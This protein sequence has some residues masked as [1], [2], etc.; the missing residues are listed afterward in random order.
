M[1]SLNYVDHDDV[2]F[3]FNVFVFFIFSKIK[4]KAIKRFRRGFNPITSY[5][6]T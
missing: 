2:S 5:E 3:D 4:T 6:V 1:L